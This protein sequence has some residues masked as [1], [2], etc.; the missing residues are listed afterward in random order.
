MN[1]LGLLIKR[2]PQVSGKEKNKSLAPLCLF[3]EEEYLSWRIARETPG[4]LKGKRWWIS[5]R[6][7]PPNPPPSRTLYIRWSAAG[8]CW[9]AGPVKITWLY[10]A[11]THT[12]EREREGKYI[13]TH[14]SRCIGKKASIQSHLPRTDRQQSF[15]VYTTD[16]LL[17]LSTK[18]FPVF[19]LFP[20]FCW[21]LD[22]FLL[23]AEKRVAHCYH[24]TLAPIG[25]D[26]SGTP[27]LYRGKIENQWIHMANM[28]VN[29]R[30]QLK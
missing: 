13:Y 25:I 9:A 5:S 3:E 8:L 20:F 1:P 10:R 17:L 23:P 24:H 2:A 15:S 27:P 4:R 21:L 11:Q 19:F 26:I 6:H 18:R 30:I 7:A 14:T 28:L 16:P 29:S 12:Q 22:G